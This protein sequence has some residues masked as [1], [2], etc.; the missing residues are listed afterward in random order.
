MSWSI[1]A[2]PAYTNKQ[3]ETDNDLKNAALVG[4]NDQAEGAILGGREGSIWGAMF[5]ESGHDEP[6]CN[7]CQNNDPRQWGGA[8]AEHLKECAT[9]SDQA[10]S[11]HD[12]E[13]FW[14]F[15]NALLNSDIMQCAEITNSDT[16]KDWRTPHAFP[17]G[18]NNGAINTDIRQC[19]RM[20]R[21]WLNFQ[22]CKTSSSSTY[23]P[24]PSF[25]DCLTPAIGDFGDGTISFLENTNL[26]VPGRGPNN[27]FRAEYSGVGK[28][29]LQ[30]K[31][32]P[33]FTSTTVCQKKFVGTQY[34]DNGFS[35]IRCEVDSQGNHPIAQDMCFCESAWEDLLTGGLWY[36]PNS[37]REDRRSNQKWYD[38]SA[39]FSY[40]VGCTP[41]SFPDAPTL[42]VNGIDTDSFRIF[43]NYSDY[44]KGGRHKDYNTESTLINSEMVSEK[45]LEIEISSVS[46]SAGFSNLIRIEGLSFWCY[47]PAIDNEEGVYDPYTTKNEKL[48]NLGYKYIATVCMKCQTNR[49]CM[50]GM[51][52]NTERKPLFPPPEGANR[53]RFLVDEEKG[54]NV[55]QQHQLLR[56]SRQR[57]LP[58]GGD[59]LPSDYP[60]G[61]DGGGSEL[62]TGDTDAKRDYPRCGKHVVPEGYEWAQSFCSEYHAFDECRPENER[63]FVV[64]TENSAVPIQQQTTYWIRARSTNT[65]DFVGSWSET[66]MVTTKCDENSLPAGKCDCQGHT[67]DVCGICNGNGIPVGKCDCQNHV[68][69]VC[70]VCRGDG[71]ADGFCDC[72]KNIP[73]PT[74]RSASYCTTLI[75]LTSVGGG[76]VGGGGGSG[77]SSSGGGTSSS[78][79]A[80]NDGTSDGTTK[81]PAN[82]T[83]FTPEEQEKRLD[84]LSNFTNDINSESSPE[85]KEELD[86]NKYVRE[87]VI[88][89]VIETIP[90]NN[91]NS[92][93]D[94]VWKLMEA[95]ASKPEVRRRFC[96]CCCCCLLLFCCCCFLCNFVSPLTPFFPP[97]H[98]PLL[99]Q[100]SVLF[101][102]SPLILRKIWPSKHQNRLIVQR[103]RSDL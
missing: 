88:T 97:P 45:H 54:E 55:E 26:Y 80:K 42:K 95:A 1:F 33:T 16:K 8:P 90:P 57:R 7:D 101:R 102:S 56:P 91:P 11:T 103:E 93:D 94:K 18:P 53:R 68:N 70:G 36:T 84:T 14:R 44:M 92:T 63:S 48:R 58:G 23:G 4:F 61:V 24:E 35:N 38:A 79:G 12:N 28:H 3:M 82:P 47:N 13:P 29:V 34:D 10:E 37:T 5:R 87:T 75:S 17:F 25:A 19:D 78:G 46:S 76:V 96:S 52:C 66:V 20:G 22:A 6:T 100:I 30:F 60:G 72:Q 77:S 98:S 41:T 32:S 49:D 2:Y 73:L 86:F 43:W 50:N 85:T 89:A 67:N 15:N 71:I 99:Y 27:Y 59:A 21:R 74:G 31:K 83:P 9:C 69:D 81:T 64:E 51:L 62:G 39:P 40:G 65:E